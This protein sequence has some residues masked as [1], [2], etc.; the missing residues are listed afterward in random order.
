MTAIQQDNARLTKELASLRQQLEVF[1]SLI[2][3][4]IPDLWLRTKLP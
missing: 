4:I 1:V 2:N 3:N